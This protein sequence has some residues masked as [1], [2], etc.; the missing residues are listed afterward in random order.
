MHKSKLFF[1]LSPAPKTPRCAGSISVP[2]TSTLG[3]FGNR[4]RQASTRLQWSSHLYCAPSCPCV[5]SSPD[6]P[7]T[8]CTVGTVQKYYTEVTVEV[9]ASIQGAPH[10]THSCFRQLCCSKKVL[11]YLMAC[12]KMPAL[13]RKKERAF[14]DISENSRWI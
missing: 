11:L 3:R 7:C 5:Q 10:S 9:P 2:G 8:L 13:H 6:A 14:I 12:R 4:R 1:L